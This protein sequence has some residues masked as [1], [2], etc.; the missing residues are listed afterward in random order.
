MLRL[1]VY[2]IAAPK[3]LRR[4]ANVCEDFGLRVQKSIFE[5]WL[6]KDRFE[7]LWK[8]LLKELDL[9]HDSLIAYTLDAA[10]AKARLQAGNHTILTEKLTRVIL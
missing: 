7:A 8:A 2:D 4:V 5:C 6:E 10:A 9:K 1:I 3:R